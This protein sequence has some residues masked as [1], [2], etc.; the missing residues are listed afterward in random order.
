MNPY[1]GSFLRSVLF[2]AWLLI[3]TKLVG[4]RHLS[5]LTFFDYVAG[6]TIG[7]IAGSSSINESTNIWSGIIAIFVWT[8]IPIVIA[9]INMKNLSFKRL[10]GGKPSIIIENG[11][12]NDEN[13]AKARYTIEDLMM[14]LRLKD[15]FDISEVEFAI[16]EINGQLSVLKKAPYNTV[17]PKDLNISTPYK[18][19]VMN[20]II[21]GKVIESNLKMA[22]KDRMWLKEQLTLRKMDKIE[23]IIFAGLTSDGKLEVISKDNTK[24]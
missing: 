16:L 18:G 19:L 6:I 2:F 12:V 7:A 22:N 3:L 23:D 14:Q 21:N 10:T 24:Q 1:T 20:L 5:E 9:S 11:T 17:T 4:K 13:M 8:M 15:V